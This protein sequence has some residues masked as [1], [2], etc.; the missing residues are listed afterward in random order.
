MG[1]NAKQTNKNRHWLQSFRHACDGVISLLRRERNARFE[2]GWAVF[3]VLLGILLD[4]DVWRFLLLLGVSLL[5]FVAEAFNTA[6]E[7]AVDLSCGGKYS[8][9]AHFAKDTAA[10]G[11][12]LSALIAVLAGIYIFLPRL[13]ELFRNI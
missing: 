13:L 1:W 2:L 10:A 7:A 9:L 8:D 11:V 5:V 4:I 12:L 3:T 6:I